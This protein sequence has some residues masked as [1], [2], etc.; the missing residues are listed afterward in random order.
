MIVGLDS[1]VV[2]R[3]LTG[4]PA[5]QALKARH[6]LER[7]HA[8][9]DEVMVSDLVVAEAYHALHYHYGVEKESARDLLHRMVTSA[10]I[11]LEPQAST[12]ALEQVAGAGV[13]DRLILHRYRAFNASTV[14]FDQQLGA[15][16]GTRL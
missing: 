9:S 2:L 6:F 1:S 15:A 8:A 5:D 3:L 13:V 11:R 16:G 7:A 10:L 14:T 12:V 4:Q